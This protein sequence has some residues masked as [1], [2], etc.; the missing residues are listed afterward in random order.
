MDDTSADTLRREGFLVARGV[1]DRDEAARYVAQIETLAGGQD[2]WTQPDG[3]NRNPQFWPI[4]F[5]E[6]LL[7]I[8]RAALGEDVRYLP[9]NDLHLG[10]SSFS[11][12]RDSVNRDAGAGPDWDESREPYRIVRIGIYLQDFASSRFKLGMIPGS[13]RPSAGLTGEE[14]RRVGRRTSALASVFSG[15]SGVDLVGDDAEWIA[16]EP[17]DA[18]I[19]DPRILHTGSKFHGMKHSMFVA[20]GVENS[21][22]R[23]HWHYYLNL[24]KDLGYSGIPAALADR[25]RDA[26]LLAEPPRETQPVEGAWIPSSAYT[27]VARKFK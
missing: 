11:W 7:R 22:F 1:I 19:F 18:V 5:N 27:Y 13:H 20:Y 2:R 10:F 16:T 15:I 21:H 17:G 4:V 12:H 25:L 8:V 14:R 9:H 26:G 23:R 6:N 24:R 3:V